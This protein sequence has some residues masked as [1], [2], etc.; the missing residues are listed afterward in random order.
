[1]NMTASLPISRAARAAA[2]VALLA[3]VPV[4]VRCS[5][6]ARPLASASVV[7]HRSQLVGGDRALGDVGDFLLENDQIRVVIQQ[8]G[9][10]KGFGVYGG[11]MIDADLRRPIEQG[12]SG[13]G[14][15]RDALGELFPAFFLQ[16]VKVD[17][18][19]I[20]DD[21]SRGG[22]ARV[23]TRGY[24]GDF[25]ELAAVLNRAATGSNKSAFDAKSAPRL[26]YS[27]E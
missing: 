1:M 26:E 21:G 11:S 14:V 25:L 17:A 7:T 3:A 18:V 5:N 27:T 4:L 15:G 12:G 23:R 24:A 6:E 2:R 8:A 10:S 19:E 20:V 9:Y 16:A 13:N 22:A